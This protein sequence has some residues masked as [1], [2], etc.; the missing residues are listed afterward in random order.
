M[1]KA[2]VIRVD[3]P[4]TGDVHVTRYIPRVHIPT[5]ISVLLDILLAI[6]TLTILFVVLAFMGNVGLNIVASSSVATSEDVS[7]ASLGMFGATFTS[8]L[9][10]GIIVLYPKA[11]MALR[12]VLIRLNLKP[13]PAGATII[14]P[15]DTPRD[16]VAIEENIDVKDESS[17]G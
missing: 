17:N 9:S 14:Q 3:D 7:A 16:T 8:G 11:H 12:R 13:V 4:T 1:P 6:C 15:D 10:A 5:F 2:P